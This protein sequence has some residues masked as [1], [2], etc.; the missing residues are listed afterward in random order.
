MAVILIECFNFL[1]D[2]V[3]TMNAK[4]SAEWISNA[5][6][7]KEVYENRRFISADSGS[8]STT[9][10]K[11]SYNKNKE[12]YEKRSDLSFIKN[13]LHHFIAF[14]PT[15]WDFMFLDFQQVA[16]ERLHLVF[17]DD[18]RFVNPHKIALRQQLL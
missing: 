12:V 6:K 16:I 7:N 13:F 11:I 9:G 15:D 3:R 8:T 4:R 1:K 2:L 18:I 10:R 14:S 17:G 5:H